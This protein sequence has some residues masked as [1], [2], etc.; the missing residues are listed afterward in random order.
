VKRED[1]LDNVGESM[2]RKEVVTLRLR[3]LNSSSAARAR[4]EA[5]TG[6]IVAV[7]EHYTGRRSLQVVLRQFEPPHK[8]MVIGLT[9]ILD[10]QVGGRYSRPTQQT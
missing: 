9:M 6:W 10:F 4:A 3:P 7:G 8:V 1:L 2:R 5:V